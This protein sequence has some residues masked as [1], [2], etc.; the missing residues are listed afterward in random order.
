MSQVCSCQTKPGTLEFDDLTTSGDDFDSW[1]LEHNLK[2]FRGAMI[3]AINRGKNRIDVTTQNVARF[4]IWLHPKM[5][6][7]A[8]PV[9]VSVD[10]T[11]RFTGRVKPS[12]KTA[13]ESYE[14]RQ[15]W[16]LIYPIKL[17]LQ[18]DD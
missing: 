14:R 5:V 7:I 16:G 9:M 1:Q 4:T 6:D 15:D 11:V 18:A 12:L 8:Q 3:D 10:G 2:E 17:E 13:L